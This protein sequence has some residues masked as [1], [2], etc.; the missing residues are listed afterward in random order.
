MTEILAVVLDGGGKGRC[1]LRLDREAQVDYRLLRGAEWGDGCASL[2]SFS[3]QVGRGSLFSL[4]ATMEEPPC[5]DP[6]VCL[7]PVT[8]KTMVSDVVPAIVGPRP[9]SNWNDGSCEEAEVTPL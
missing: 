7:L 5:N 2:T 9:A 6:L 4:E 1:R 3:I 8:K